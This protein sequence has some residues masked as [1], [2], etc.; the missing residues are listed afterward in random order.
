MTDL[1]RLLAVAGALCCAAAVALAALAMHAVQGHAALQAGVAAAF[2]FA[3]GLAL[4]L[5]VAHTGRLGTAALVL[6]LVG[7]GLFAGSLAG[8][9]FAGLPTTAAPAGGIVL[10]LSWVLLA[11]DAWRR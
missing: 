3:H 5:L 1:Q 10:M 9:A 2:A 7:V 4:H 6:M 8:A 11:V